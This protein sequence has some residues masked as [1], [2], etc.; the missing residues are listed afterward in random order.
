MLYYF[1]QHCF[2]CLPSDSTVWEDAAIEPRTVATLAL[3]FRRS[4]CTLLDFIKK[5]ALSTNEPPG[6]VTVQKAQIL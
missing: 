5:G 3:A 4:N 6:P 1:I 2:I